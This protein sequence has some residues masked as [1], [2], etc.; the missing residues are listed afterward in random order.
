MARSNALG[1]GCGGRRVLGRTGA[2]RKPKPKDNWPNMKTDK[3]AVRAGDGIG[4]EVIPAGMDVLTI[5]ASQ[6]GFKCE[7]TEF[8]WGCDYYLKHGRM[9]DPDGITTV[10][11]FDAISLGAIGDPRVADYISAR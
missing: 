7:F 2:S 5:A 8:P 11:T 10:M 9:L 4:K 3:I 6:G 1:P